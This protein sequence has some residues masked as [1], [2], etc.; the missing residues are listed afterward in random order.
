MRV[1][2][3]IRPASATRI[4]RLWLQMI[5]HRCSSSSNQRQIQITQLV[6]SWVVVNKAPTIIIMTQWATTTHIEVKMW[7]LTLVV[8]ARHSLLIRIRFRRSWIH[9][10]LRR[11]PSSKTATMKTSNHH[12]HS[13]I[14]QA[15]TLALQ[16]CSLRRLSAWQLAGWNFDT[17]KMRS[18]LV[19]R[20]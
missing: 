8:A 17:T 9:C 10:W 12:L 1:K 2:L 14:F 18:V 11:K 20:I 15:R 19:K 7:R 3:S 16:R 5:S 4:R 13:T 6:W